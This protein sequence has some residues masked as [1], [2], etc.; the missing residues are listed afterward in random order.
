M[1]ADGNLVGYAT[2]LGGGYFWATNRFLPAGKAVRGLVMQGDGNLVAYCTDGFVL[3]ASN[4]N[5]AVGPAYEL[6]VQDDGNLVMYSG[7]ATA[8]VAFWESKTRVPFTLITSGDT[9][10]ADQ[11]YRALFSN[12]AKSSIMANECL[13]SKRSGIRLCMQFDGNIVAYATA[14]RSFW[15]TASGNGAYLGPK[16]VQ[17]LFMQGDGNLVAYA[18]DRSVVWASNTNRAIGPLYELRIQDDGNLVMYANGASF[19]ASNS[20]GAGMREFFLAISSDPQ[21]GSFQTKDNTINTGVYNKPTGLFESR[22]ANRVIK[23]S[24]M[25]FKNS[26][27]GDFAGMFITGDLTAEGSQGHNYDDFDDIYVQNT[28]L[29]GAMTSIGNVFI[30]YGNHDFQKP[31]DDGCGNNYWSCA[32]DIRSKMND[33]LVNWGAPTFGSSFQYE[34]DSAPGSQVS[35]AYS[36]E[37]NGYT[38]IM[39]HLNPYADVIRE[40][41]R[42]GPSRNWAFNAMDI[43]KNKG[44]K[45]VLFIH[46]ILGSQP[47]GPCPGRTC[48][49]RDLTTDADFGNKLDA[50][51]VVAIFRGHTHGPQDSNANNR[52]PDGHGLTETIRGVP[53]FNSGAAWYYTYQQTAWRY[54]GFSVTTNCLDPGN[55]YGATVNSNTI[56]VTASFDTASNRWIPATPAAALL[57]AFSCPLGG[58]RDCVGV[59]G[60]CFAND[61]KCCG[62]SEQCKPSGFLR[63]SCIG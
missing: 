2:A 1:Q 50:S 20:L 30:G 35:Q 16:V 25:S 29:N 42:V 9:Y 62:G 27:G 40:G 13:L 60:N 17:G 24:V 52:D 63:A 3:W 11:S 21:F 44:N 28:Y 61:P 33:R 48:W 59:G 36:W 5:R 51:S 6:R 57:R 32:E 38:F 54:W 47:W 56:D 37:K 7:P 39:M 46:A 49:G 58:P 23:N 18:T 8:P 53:V 4:T 41:H 55:F 15:Q 45:V 31:L 12:R 10:S 14:G 43:A 19:W 34:S 22:W 26:K